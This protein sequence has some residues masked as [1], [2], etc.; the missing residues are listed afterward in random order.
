V[1]TMREISRCR[2][3]ASHDKTLQTRAQNKR[4]ELQEMRKLVLGIDRPSVIVQIFELL[5]QR[6]K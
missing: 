5:G 4:D 2:G 3:G 6:E 1:G